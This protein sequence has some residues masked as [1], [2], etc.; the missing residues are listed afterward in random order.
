MS[1]SR[2]SQVLP[3]NIRKHW[4]WKERE[5]AASPRGKAALDVGYGLGAWAARGKVGSN[6]QNEDVASEQELAAGS[7]M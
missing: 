1:N 7:S 6:G 5:S 4:L 3:V 2:N